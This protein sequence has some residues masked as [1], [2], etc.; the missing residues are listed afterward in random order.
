MGLH[1][2]AEPGRMRVLALLTGD[3]A[4]RRGD[5]GVKYGEMFAALGA[6]C[7]L[8][9]VRDVELRGL[10]RYQGAARTLRWPLR[11]WRE[12]FYKNPWAYQRR[13]RRAAE[14]ARRHA[15]QVDLIFQHGA[16]FRA[17]AGVGGPPVVL[18]ADFTYRLAQREDRWRDP[19]ADPAQGERWNAL[20][21]AALRGAAFVLTRSEHTR[22]SM[23]EDYAIA[24]ERVAVV[25]GGLNFAQMP[26]LMP[27]ADRPR[28]LFVGRDYERKG[29]DL[30]VAAFAR[31]RERIPDAELWLV[32]AETGV[33]GPGIRR[34]A[35][36]Y[37]RA[38]LAELYRGAAVFA[39]PS[40]CETWGDVFLEAMA[41][42]LP[43][44]GAA[45]DAMPEIIRH[46]ETGYLAPPGD[47]GALAAYLE[48]L[49]ASPLLRQ[50][51]GAR[52]RERVATMFTWEHVLRRM[53]PYFEQAR[54][55][56]S[57]PP[58]ERAEHARMVGAR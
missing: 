52:G 13:S 8:V 32:T 20:E 33:A 26:T 5:A 46:G 51:L 28:V 55:A 25:G 27:P 3:L 36:V 15:G 49:L 47:V 17:D 29:G 41:H 56:A 10:D 43:C 30:L 19:F 57:A 21:A 22:R 44:V 48:R 16:L 53:L 40:R 31:V 23:I 54:A 6:Q 35:P 24:P 18:Y 14:L 1:N 38:A 58:R 42:G 45:V 4:S 50:Q 37:D 39:M 7:D 2:T 9:E 34:I 12:A 11:S